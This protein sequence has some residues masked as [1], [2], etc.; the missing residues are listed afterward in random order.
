VKDIP[1][2]LRAQSGARGPSRFAMRYCPSEQ[3]K[4]E[5]HHEGFKCVQCK[6]VHVPSGPL[7]GE[8]HSIRGRRK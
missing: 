4:E 5:T 1:S 7:W 3:C 2:A 6:R 8:Q